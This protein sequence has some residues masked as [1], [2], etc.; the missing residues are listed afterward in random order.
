[1][2]LIICA[3]DPG[4]EGAFAVYNLRTGQLEVY[5]MPLAVKQLTGG[6][7]K[8]VLSEP[9]VLVLAARLKSEGVR[10]VFIEDVGG[11]PRQSAPAAFNF[12]YGVG[13]VRMAL[14]AHGLS[15]HPV[16]PQTW[17][18]ALR[19]PAEK[20]GAILRANE[21]LPTHAHLWSKSAKGS[22]GLKAGRAEAA[23]IALYGERV[24]RNQQ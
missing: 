12:G 4:L 21:L 22:A 24:L 11:L 7:R 6:K 9:D 2:D 1:M 5:D 15:V 10:D 23:M 14:R 19:C 13:V 20:D 18:K 8:Q 3:I 17:K 16:I